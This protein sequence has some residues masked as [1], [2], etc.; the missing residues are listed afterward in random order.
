[1]GFFLRLGKFWFTLLVIALGFYVAHF[2]NTLVTLH[3]PP[4]ID[5][6]NVPASIAFMLWFMIGA[7]AVSFFFGLDIMRKGWT[8]RRLNKKIRSYETQLGV[9]STTAAVGDISP[10]DR[11]ASASHLSRY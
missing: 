5:T 8:I 1:M 10:A 2:N 3:L 11:D 6:I 9:G 4:I 7:G